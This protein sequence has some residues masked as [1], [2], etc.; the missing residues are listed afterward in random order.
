MPQPPLAPEV[1]NA[2]RQALVETGYRV[3]EAQ[4]RLRSAGI[5]VSSGKLS[6]IK[7]DL[8]GADTAEARLA[9]AEARVRS[10][11]SQLT[12][13]KR[14]YG[15]ALEFNDE[16]LGAVHPITPYPPSPVRAKA[17]TTPVAAV[18]LLSDWHVGEIIR[19]AEIAGINSFNYHVA[20]ARAA[21]LTRA[22]THWVDT[23]RHGYQINECHILLLGDFISGNIH[24]E[25]VTT[26]EFPT[27]V[28]VVRSAELLASTVAGIAPR[29]AKRGQK[30]VL[31]EVYADNHA[32]LTRKPQSKRACTNT[33]NYPLYAL[34]NAYLSKHR[35]VVVHAYE[36]MKVQTP[37]AVKEVLMD[38]GD[39]VRSWLGLP[40][41]GMMREAGQEAIMRLRYCKP[42]D[43][44]IR[45][46]WHTPA[47]GPFGVVNGAFCGT[48][49]LDF[50]NGRFSH[51]SQTS[52]LMH[53]RYGKFNHTD[54]DLAPA[55]KE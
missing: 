30:V 15:E 34:L 19:S 39:S 6:G 2:A 24:E 14:R 49:E 1:I 29:F 33:F 11:S 35:N 8:E 32:R 10:L 44:R 25:L 48:T 16:V 7:R 37:I 23:N 51:P 22:F 54:W 13:L 43:L 53:P 52:F 50:K 12:T 31:H 28:Q 38:H 45:A 3:A 9:S 18:L 27:P 4:R 5:K 20:A 21:Y 40:Y 46:H 36:S 17:T 55:T 41:Y 47:S 42:Y 26:A